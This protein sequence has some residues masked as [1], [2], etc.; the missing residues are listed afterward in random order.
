MPNPVCR[1]YGSMSRGPVGERTWALITT[2]QKGMTTYRILGVEV[3]ALW[4]PDASL[5]RLIYL[6][7]TALQYPEPCRRTA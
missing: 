4:T 1:Y 7:G 6:A 3:T 2:L 5:Y